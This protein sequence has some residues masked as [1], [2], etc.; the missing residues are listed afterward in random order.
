MKK[1]L[2]FFYKTHQIF[3]GLCLRSTKIAFFQKCNKSKLCKI[4]N[5]YRYFKLSKC[6]GG[7]FLNFPLQKF[8]LAL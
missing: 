3:Q 2:A 8:K 6:L 5:K 7:Q 4:C 1:K